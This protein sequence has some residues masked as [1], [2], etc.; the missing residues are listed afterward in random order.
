MGVAEGED[1]GK[2]GTEEIPLETTMTEKLPKL[3]S[4]AI[5]PRSLENTK[6]QKCQ[7]TTKLFL[8]MSFLN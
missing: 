2:L 1:R 4:E 8:G 3:M 7:A 6:Q 5:Y